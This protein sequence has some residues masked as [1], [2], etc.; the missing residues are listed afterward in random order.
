MNTK[1]VI[2]NCSNCG[3]ISNNEK[4]I[5]NFKTPNGI[6]CPQ[7]TKIS[8]TVLTQ[9]SADLPRGHPRHWNRSQRNQVCT[10]CKGTRHWPDDNWECPH[11]DG[12]GV[13]FSENDDD[14]NPF[15]KDEYATKFLE[16]IGIQTDEISIMDT[17]PELVRE[18]SN[19]T[20][21]W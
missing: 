9:I 7:C 2:F 21:R 8:N 20:R 3:Y 4:N 12:Y 5:A 16:H 11:C 13:L 17:N 19:M 18:Q 14:R 6:E 15:W 10:L 1:V